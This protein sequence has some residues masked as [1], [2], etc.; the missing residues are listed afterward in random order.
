M[1]RR[2]WAAV[3]LAIG[4]MPQTRVP[5]APHAFSCRGQ[6]AAPRETRW[7]GLPA[8]RL[9]IHRLDAD[10][11]KPLDQVRLRVLAEG[12]PLAAFAGALSDALGIAVTVDDA[13]L[14]TR[15]AL[16]LPDIDVAGLWRLLATT[17]SIH[18]ALYER[19][20]HFTHDITELGALDRPAPAPPETAGTETTLVTPPIEA[21][22]FASAF[23]EQIASPRGAASVVGT[24]VLLS[25]VPERLKLAERMLAALRESQ[26]R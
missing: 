9:E 5:V 2:W 16:A 21:E 6:A 10:A 25:D 22:Q 14:G 8:G 11:S 18:V 1:M 12:V 15:I 24:R 7:E 20:I 3:I 26:A 23:C 19:T 17:Q 4:C 13:S